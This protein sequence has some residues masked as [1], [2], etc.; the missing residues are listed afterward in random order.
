MTACKHGDPTCPCQDGDLCH[1]EGMDAWCA[2]L[3]LVVPYTDLRPETYRAT[4]DWPGVEYVYV[5]GDDYEYGRLLRELWRDGQSFLLCEHDM[6]PTREQLLSMLDCEHGY[7]SSPY[8]W[9]TTVGPALGFTRFRDSF[10]ATYPDAAEIACRIPSNYGEPGHW[11]QLDVWLMA[12]V[13]RDWYGEQ[14]H[15]HLPPV[16]HLNKGQALLPIHTGKPAV[17]SVQGRTHLAP[18]TVERIAA[19]VLAGR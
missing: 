14:P 5:G 9:T 15:C 17:T 7:C 16:E 13:L 12:A 1:Y 19:E 11:K 10:T 3:R 18:G 6:N 2:P 8:A 4:K